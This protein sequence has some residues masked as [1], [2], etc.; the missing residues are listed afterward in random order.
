MISTL[1]GW[2]WP[3]QRGAMKFI[4]IHDLQYSDL[5]QNLNPAG[6]EPSKTSLL[7]MLT[8]F[9]FPCII[10]NRLGSV[11][12]RKCL[13]LVLRDHGNW[14]RINTLVHSTIQWPLASMDSHCYFCCERRS[15]L[16]R[17]RAQYNSIFNVPGNIQSRSVPSHT[18][19][20]FGNFPHGPFYDCRHDLFSM[21]PGLGA[22]G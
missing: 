16:I 8:V 18:I 14:D 11:A 6:E 22:L 4:A 12:D 1:D 3:Q 21:C 13:Q 10:Q 19:D 17:L 2:G 9:L 15:F 7:R 20:V 5:F